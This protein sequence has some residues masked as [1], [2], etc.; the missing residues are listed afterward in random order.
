M[1]RARFLPAQSMAGHTSVD[2]Q[3]CAYLERFFLAEVNRAARGSFSPW[4]RPEVLQEAP[5]SRSL[6]ATCSISTR[7]LDR[8]PVDQMQRFRGAA[9]D[10][11][12]ARR[13]AANSLHRGFH[14][15]GSAFPGLGFDASVFAMC[16]SHAETETLSGK[17][18]KSAS[19]G[20]SC[21]GARAVV[22]GI[23]PHATKCHRRSKIACG[24]KRRNAVA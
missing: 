9:H 3:G 21:L 12:P 1:S 14:T 2:K 7:S 13:V 8:W 5:Y 24:W 18:V 17:L 11:I 20:R 4:S 22:N 16:D 19:R 10:N 6:S 15:Q 23:F